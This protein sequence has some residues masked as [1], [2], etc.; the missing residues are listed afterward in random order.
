M[1]QWVIYKNGQRDKAFDELLDAKRYAKGL[2]GDVSVRAEDRPGELT[3]AQAAEQEAYQRRYEEERKAAAYG[4]ISTSPKTGGEFKGPSATEPTIVTYTSGETASFLPSS[5]DVRLARGGI[6]AKQYIAETGKIPENDID[7]GSV[8]GQWGTQTRAEGLKPAMKQYEPGTPE[9]EA[10]RYDISKMTPEQQAYIKGG[11]TRGLTTEEAIQSDLFPRERWYAAYSPKDKNYTEGTYYGTKAQAEQYKIGEE[12]RYLEKY[13]PEQTQTPVLKSIF[14]VEGGR[15]YQ[16]IPWSTGTDIS[17]KRGIYEANKAAQEGAAAY[18]KYKGSYQELE[19][20]ISE[21][22]G[23][24]PVVSDF[25][26]WLG[27]V[28]EYSRRT[29]DIEAAKGGIGLGIA[30]GK[31]MASSFA[32]VFR[33]SSYAPIVAITIGVPVKGTLNVLTGK[34]KETFKLQSTASEIWGARATFIGA[35]VVQHP[36]RF[37]STLAGG[38]LAGAA[39]GI[40]Y[41][42]L[43]PDKAVSTRFFK[44]VD[45]E[46]AITF[47]EQ[48]TLITESKGHIIV[49]TK[50]T[51]GKSVTTAFKGDIVEYA[52]VDYSKH[53]PLTQAPIGKIA[54]VGFEQYTYKLASGQTAKIHQT[55]LSGEPFTKGMS[56]YTSHVSA[57]TTPTLSISTPFG[58]TY[59]ESTY[60]VSGAGNVRGLTIVR[61]KPMDFE[62]VMTGPAKY[63]GYSVSASKT[64][65]I[66]IFGAPSSKALTVSQEILAVQSQKVSTLIKSAEI[67]LQSKT[68]ALAASTSTLISGPKLKTESMTASNLTSKTSSF[69]KTNMASEAGLITQKVQVRAPISTDAKLQTLSASKLM[70]TGY[71]STLR[72]PTRELFISKPASFTSTLSGT[73]TLIVPIAPLVVS[74]ITSSKIP[75]HPGGALTS[76]IPE[77]ASSLKDLLEVDNILKKSKQKVTKLKQKTKYSPSIAAGEFNIYA[78]KAPKRLTGLE[79]RPILS[80]KRR[81][82]LP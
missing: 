44:E 32:S 59:T 61:L 51:S 71:G 6:T 67:A 2:S 36:F 74:Q 49:T 21:G 13:K 18:A 9:Y 23:K 28:S 25:D 69:S 70:R 5:A 43:L 72:T 12:A 55:V 79:I 39:V 53:I 57:V 60:L 42:K 41:N 38:Y 4:A 14:S 7:T 47:K 75:V 8:Y 19:S 56:E 62:Q 50:L 65:Q 20:S 37:G 29:G 45:V 76:K 35:E 17:A 30:G 77:R 73:S 82:G 33:P 80:G 1:G 11:I 27:D 34:G 58:K 40:A 3:G 10:Q 22:I 64:G 48:N 52:A 26:R 31:Y 63:S 54:A 78:K 24:I 15:L 66:Q 81:G 16:A 68:G 46:K